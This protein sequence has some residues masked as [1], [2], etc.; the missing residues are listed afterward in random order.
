MSLQRGRAWLGR[1]CEQ[2]LPF[3]VFMLPWASVAPSSWR[4]PAGLGTRSLAAL[5]RRFAEYFCGWRP[6]P[7][8]DREVTGP[9][10]CSQT[11]RLYP[12]SATS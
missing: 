11:L 10:F 6:S 1:P 3:L 9:G 8:G 12:G 7:E 5:G 2:C 4:I